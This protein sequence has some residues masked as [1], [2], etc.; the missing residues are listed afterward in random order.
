MDGTM[1]AVIRIRGSVNVPTE[2]KD[3]LQML[4][5]TRVNHCVLIPK[6][7]NYGG[8]LLKAQSFITWGEISQ[9]TLERLVAK[10]GRKTGDERLSEKEAKDISRKIIKDSSVKDAGIKPVFRL[11]PPTKGYRSIRM[12][13]PR[14]DL[15]KRGEAINR[16]IKR[17][18]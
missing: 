18:I 3:T 17:M 7:P 16:L 2:V 5:L 4:R 14:G 12:A 1:L 10:R 8:M 15:G 9:G 11:S 13:Y 6:D